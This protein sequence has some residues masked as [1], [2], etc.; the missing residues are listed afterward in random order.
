MLR[1]ALALRFV[2]TALV[3]SLAATGISWAF[4]PGRPTY[5]IPA[6]AGS[7]SKTLPASSPTWGDAELPARPRRGI[8]RVE[9]RPNR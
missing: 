2:L 1:G 8:H 4:L 6:Y 3:T 7:I 5:I 9:G